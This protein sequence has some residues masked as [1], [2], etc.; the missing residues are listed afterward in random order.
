[1]ARLRISPV[2][3]SPTPWGKYSVGDMMLGHLGFAGGEDL[4]MRAIRETF[5]VGIATADIGGEANHP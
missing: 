1:M 5:A 3:G 2:G 4:L